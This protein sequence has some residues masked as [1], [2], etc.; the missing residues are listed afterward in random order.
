MFNDSLGVDGL[1]SNQTALQKAT[2]YSETQESIRAEATRLHALPE[3]ARW[4]NW[5]VIAW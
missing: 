2:D 3:K 1:P 5:I 4:K